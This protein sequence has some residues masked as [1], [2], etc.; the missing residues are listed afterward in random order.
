MYKNIYIIICR[1]LHDMIYYII[2]IHNL[3]NLFTDSE[4]KRIG[5]GF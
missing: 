4:T 1:Y 2:K 3:Q 5:I